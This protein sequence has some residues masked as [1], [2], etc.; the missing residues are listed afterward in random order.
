[1]ENYFDVQNFSSEE[2]GVEV[3][4][5]LLYGTHDANQ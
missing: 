4:G 5:C 2:P 1:M 3:I